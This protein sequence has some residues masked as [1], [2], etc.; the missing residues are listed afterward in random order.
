MHVTGIPVR[1]NIIRDKMDIADNVL[2]LTSQKKTL[3]IMGG[4][5]GSSGDK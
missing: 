4:S 3:L 1:N 5:Q 2:G